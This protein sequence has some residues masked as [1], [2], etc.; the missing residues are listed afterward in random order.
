MLPVVDRPLI[1]YAVEGQRT[2]QL[3]DVQ[4][5]PWELN[6]LADDPGYAGHLRRLRAELL[7]W[8]DELD[9]D[10]ETFWQHCSVEI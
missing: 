10:K 2:T 3:F 6:N 7:R 8:R 1:E 4:T 5:D 9:D